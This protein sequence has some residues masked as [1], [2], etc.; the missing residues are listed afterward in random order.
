MIYVCGMVLS[1]DGWMDG[2]HGWY[3]CCLFCAQYVR[4]SLLYN[5]NRCLDLDVR[6][7]LMFDVFQLHSKRNDDR[8]DADD[9]EVKR[10][11][12]SGTRKSN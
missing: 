4:Y 5:N 12:S 7:D 10:F 11:F 2:M 9:G 8:D 3:S 6:F 1:I